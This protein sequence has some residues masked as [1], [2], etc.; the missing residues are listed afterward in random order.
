MT[1]PAPQDGRMKV[2]FET[3]T[4]G[5]VCPS[6]GYSLQGLDV[7]G[8]CPECGTEIRESQP[9]IP[10]V[11]RDTQSNGV[12]T[13]LGDAPLSYLLP[14]SFGLLGMGLSGLGVVSGVAVLLF[15]EMDRS[16]RVVL[17]L[18]WVVWCVSLLVVMRARPRRAANDPDAASRPAEWWG[19]KLVLVVTQPAMILLPGAM[20]LWGSSSGWTAVLPWLV[21]GWVAMGWPA[22]AML[23]RHLAQWA[24]HDSM[25]DRLLAIAWGLGVGCVGGLGMMVAE[26]SIP[27][28]SLLFFIIGT[29]VIVW[30]GSLI[31]LCVTA[32][33][34]VS[35]VRWS[36]VNMREKAARDARILERARRANARALPEAFESPQGVPLASGG[37]IGGMSPRAPAAQEAESSSLPPPG[38][39]MP[40]S[41]VARIEANKE[42]NP[43]AVE[44]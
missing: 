19:C 20:Y 8:N 6:C 44:E 12:P 11:V 21:L 37:V 7:R 9:S 41:S 32:L 15:G 31:V 27:W 17:G 43:Y 30:L 4:D 34:M 13:H 28:L 1:A 14:L 35:I 42:L 29:A 40:G 24:V 2:T 33:Q 25:A 39:P 16:M 38:T 23:L 18:V 5:R 10:S 22:A 3:V 36:V 26:W